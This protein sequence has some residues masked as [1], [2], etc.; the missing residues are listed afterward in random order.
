MDNNWICNDSKF[1]SKNHKVETK[2]N[3]NPLLLILFFY[4]SL[5]HSCEK[6]TKYLLSILKQR[7]ILSPGLKSAFYGLGI[8]LRS[9]FD[10]LLKEIKISRYN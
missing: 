7:Q 5:F 2:K 3:I 1:C 9:S 10:Y 8:L 6:H 4:F